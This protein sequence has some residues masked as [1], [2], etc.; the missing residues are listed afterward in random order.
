M[1]YLKKHPI[2]LVLILVLFYAIF[3]SGWSGPGL[4]GKLTTAGLLLTL[5]VMIRFAWEEKTTRIRT[6]MFSLVS[7][8]GGRARFKAIIVFS[9]LGLIFT[10]IEAA[11]ELS[12]YLTWK[13][14]FPVVIGFPYAAYSFSVYR[15]LYYNILLDTILNASI[16][17]LI[18]SF[19]FKEQEK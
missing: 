16:L 4:L 15:F 1:K 9:L 14:Y 10:L 5:V 8:Q 3:R 17:Y 18:S 7:N 12:V 19:L 2:E 13:G 11:L 6:G